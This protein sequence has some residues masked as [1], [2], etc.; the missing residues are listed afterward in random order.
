MSDPQNSDHDETQDGRHS[1][2]PA[3]EI[4][5]TVSLT[6]SIRGHVE[7]GGLRYHAYHAGKYPFPNDEVEQGRDD[8]MHEMMVTL[9]NSDFSA[10]VADVLEKG[11]NVLD[12][13]A[14]KYPCSDF[15]GTDLSPIQPETVP[16]NVQFVL[17]DYEHEEGWAD[18][19]ETYDFIHCRRIANTVYNMPRLLK[20]IHDHAATNVPPRHLKPGGWVEFRDLVHSFE[21]D[22][23][24][25]T[26]ETTYRPR[27]FIGL[28]VQ[29][30][31]E[32]GTDVDAVFKM[33]SYLRDA[34]FINISIQRF[35]APIGRWPTDVT[36]QFCG[37][38]LR[39]CFHDGLV[40]MARKPL[41]ALNWT[42]LQIEMFLVEVRQHINDPRYHVYMPFNI[43]YAQ[44]PPKD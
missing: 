34:G 40:G 29:G 21:C 5:E 12:L 6:E 35:K 16:P 9:A 36:Y 37:E 15:V 17:D 20:Q 26:E 19:P 32:I 28:L 38:I 23:A 3:T 18:E 22:D 39:E 4:A 8:M 41:M 44:K 7:E 10:P 33:E 14:D 27:D 11:A 24:S 43:I 25:M 13:V 30:L 31:T 1:P 42:K 2:R